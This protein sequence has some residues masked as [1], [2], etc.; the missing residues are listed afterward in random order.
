MIVGGDHQI[1]TPFYR[2]VTKFHGY[3][4]GGIIK[5]TFNGSLKIDFDK[6]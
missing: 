2:G 1:L 6:S 5:L 3:K 4:M